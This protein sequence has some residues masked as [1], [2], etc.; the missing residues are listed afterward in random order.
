MAAALQPEAERTGN[1]EH[2][3]A[4]Q[5]QFS[6]ARRHGAILPLRRRGPRETGFPPGGHAAEP[7]AEPSAP[8]TSVSLTRCSNAKSCLLSRAERSASAVST[9]PRR[10][11]RCACAPVRPPASG[12]PAS[13]ACRRVGCGVRPSHW[14]RAG[15]SCG[16][17]S[18]FRPPSSRRARNATRR[19]GGAG[20]S[21]P[22]IG[23]GDPEP[24]HAAIELRPQQA[25][26]VRD[27]DTNV[28]FGIRHGR[29]CSRRAIG[30]LG[31]YLVS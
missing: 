15:R 12:K 28:F 19:A 26:D 8:E 23:A 7:F 21:A 24:A 16:R 11:A 2:G 29:N 27:H 13:R 5:R 25:G 1:D 6:L 30:K 3:H 17:R 9:V 4:D 18:P 31:Y 10:P 22:A 14:P 20:G